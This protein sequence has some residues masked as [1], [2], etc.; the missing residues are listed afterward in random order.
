MDF[1]FFPGGSKSLLHTLFDDVEFENRSHSITLCNRILALILTTIENPDVH[2]D[3]KPDLFQD[4]PKSSMSLVLKC[5]QDGNMEFLKILID[6]TDNMSSEYRTNY[7]GKENLLNYG[8][9]KKNIG[10]P[11]V[12]PL[13]RA[14]AMNKADFVKILLENGADPKMLSYQGQ[15]KISPLTRAIQEDE[16]EFIT[17]V[18]QKIREQ[19]KN[20]NGLDGNAERRLKTIREPPK[21][22][23]STCWGFCSCWGSAKNTQSPGIVKRLSASGLQGLPVLGS[24]YGTPE[25]EEHVEAESEDEDSE[26]DEEAQKVVE[27]PRVIANKN[28]LWDSLNDF[29]QEKLID[30]F[31]ITAMDKSRR[32]EFKKM[33]NNFCPSDTTEITRTT[34]DKIY[35]WKEI[36]TEWTRR[37]KPIN[38]IHSI[39][40]KSM[41]APAQD[42]YEAIEFVIKTIKDKGGPQKASL[43]VEDGAVATDEKISPEEEKQAEAV[44]YVFLFTKP[45]LRDRTFIACYLQIAQRYS[46]VLKA[47]KRLRNMKHMILL[48]TV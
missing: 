18:I 24:F 29:D 13:I 12:T 4:D 14:I 33:L 47:T 1:K 35:Y 19:L 32:A 23:C 25:V 31:C 9:G 17:G 11:Q 40:Q 26:T 7:R 22:G 6:A 36:S 21:E 30:F 3:N 20:A 45:G 28:S 41:A 46:S 42:P 16:D 34:V 15:Q 8:G 39:L 43:D 5:V 38:L 48:F 10:K 44:T 37:W 2:K 27:E